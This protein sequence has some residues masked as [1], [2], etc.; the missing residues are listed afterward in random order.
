MG[1][2][3][4]N[5][6][7]CY[8]LKVIPSP[9]CQCGYSPEDPMHFFFSCPIFHAQRLTLLNTIARLSN[10]LIIRTLLYGDPEISFENN[11][12]LFNAVYDYII[13]THQFDNWQGCIW[14]RSPSSS[15]STQHN[16]QPICSLI[17]LIQLYD[18]SLCNPY[19][20]STNNVMNYSEDI[21]LWHLWQK[22]L[23]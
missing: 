7:L 19:R 4:L 12:S 16:P 10:N 9:Q 18:F 8:N 23:R 2:S 22:F 1:C 5:A 14:V 20:N 21:T 15:P 17:E 11:K 6:H 13:K 3:K